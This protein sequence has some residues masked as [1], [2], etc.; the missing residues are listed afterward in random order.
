MPSSEFIDLDGLVFKGLENY[1]DGD[2][3]P[4]TRFRYQQSG[5]LVQA[6]F[7]GGGVRVGTMVGVAEG[8]EIAF[9]WQ[10]VSMRNTLHQGDCITKPSRRE[11][12]GLVVLHERWRIHLP[13]K[14]AGISATIQCTNDEQGDK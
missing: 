3:G 5:E 13:V 6:T 2:F 9:V 4:E 14:E 10:Y 11:D 1:D 7:Q 8:A 12:D